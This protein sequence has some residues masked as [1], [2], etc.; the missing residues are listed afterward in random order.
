MQTIN[1]AIVDDHPLII[2]GLVAILRPYTQIVVRGTYTSAAGLLEGLKKDC[3]DVLLLDILLPDVSGKELITTIREAYPALRVLV[4]TSLDMPSMVSSMLRRGCSGYLLKGAPS[5]T[6]IDAIEAVH[7]GGEYIEPKL[8][9]QLFQNF[10]RFKEHPRNQIV[11]PE[12][13]QRE[14]EVLALIAAE[15]TTREIADK[16]FI[17]YYTAENH[18]NNLIQKLDVKNTAGLIKVAIQIGLLS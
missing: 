13:T 14:K 18:R 12:L 6:L 1:I 5:N 17:S 9:E 8:K 15:Y 3:P 11:V 7:G 4:L 10:L 16:L 2:S